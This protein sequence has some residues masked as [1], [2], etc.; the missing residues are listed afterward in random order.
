M[1]STVWQ[2]LDL[3]ARNLLPVSFT[4]LLIMIGML[5]IRPPDASAI[6]PSM[7]LIAVF[8]WTIYR[9]DLMPEWAVF[10][11]GLFQDLMAGGLVGLGTLVL[12]LVQQVVKTQRRTCINAPFLLCWAIFAL[13]VVGAQSVAWLLTCGLHLRLVSPMPGVFEG[14]LTLAFFPPLAWIFARMQ[15]LLLR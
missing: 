6:V 4:I 1:K 2:R 14:L 9:P 10:L 8:F 11:I 15:R 12:L 13:V 5:P 7:A 3:V